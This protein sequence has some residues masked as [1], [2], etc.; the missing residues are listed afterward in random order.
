M[1]SDLLASREL[2]WCLAVRD[3]KAKY[4]QSLLGV[5]WAFLPPVAIALLF[6]AVNRAGV[7]NVGE[8]AIPYPAFVLFGTTLWYIF[9]RSLTT[10]LDAIRAGKAM[11][12]KIN[13]PREAIALSALGQALFDAGIRLVILGAVFVIFQLPLTWGLLL[14]PLAVLMLVLLGTMIGLLLTPLGVLYTDVTSA[15]STIGP[16]WLL[17]TPVVY[18]PPDRWPYSLIV[19]LNPVSPLLVGAR[20][21]ATRGVL[22]DP[23][24]FAIVSGLTVLG[25][26]VVWVL[27]R[28]SIPILIERMGS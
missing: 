6:V 21:L 4:R 22:V 15:L 3:I 28:I 17:L 13:F 26:L 23:L 10:P 12:V 24:A 18:P 14:A 19:D 5:V 1:W 9:F 16:I 20:D 27:Y 2:A 7:I 8:T 25:L 11:L